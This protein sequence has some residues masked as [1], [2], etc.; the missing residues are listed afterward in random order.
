MANE[1]LALYQGDGDPRILTYVPGR[2]WCIGRSPTADIRLNDLK[3][4]RAH[5]LIQ[6]QPLGGDVIAWFVKHVGYNPSRLIRGLQNLQLP[7]GEWVLVQ[8]GDALQVVSPVHQFVLTC[9]IDDTLEVPLISTT[10]PP[11]EAA[12]VKAAH[13]P[14]GLG[15]PDVVAIVLSGPPGFPAWLWWLLLGAVALAVIVIWLGAN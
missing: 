4:S 5:C 13:H 10:A 2:T 7:P 12:P 6:G 14:Q 11:P 15:W 8:D 1:K 3:V 9:D